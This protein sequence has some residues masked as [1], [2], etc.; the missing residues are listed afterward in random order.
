MDKLTSEQ[1]NYITSLLEVERA[2]TIDNILTEIR[3]RRRGTKDI[4]LL[5]LLDSYVQTVVKINNILDDMRG[6]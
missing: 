3:F 6:V 1:I 2:K 4:I 5:A